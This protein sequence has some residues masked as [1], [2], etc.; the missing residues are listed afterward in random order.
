LNDDLRDLIERGLVQFQEKNKKFDLH[1]IVRH[2]SYCCLGPT[3]RTNAH[4]RLANYFET[5]LRPKK[6]KTLEVLALMIELYHHTVS[7]GEFD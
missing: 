6:E 3:D 4:S 2:Y 7:M 5:L 1:P